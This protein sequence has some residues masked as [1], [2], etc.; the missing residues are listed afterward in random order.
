MVVVEATL[1]AVIHANREAPDK[2]VYVSCTCNR[3]GEA[4]LAVRDEGDRMWQLYRI[5]GFQKIGQSMLNCG[6]EDINVIK[7]WL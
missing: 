4:W 5:P 1:D 3:V 2:R 6:V 7:V